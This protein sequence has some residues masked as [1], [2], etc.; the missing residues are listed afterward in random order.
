MYRSSDLSISH[1][2]RSSDGPARDPPLRADHFGCGARMVG[3]RCSKDYALEARADA[4]QRVL[5]CLKRC[6]AESW[7][8]LMLCSGQW[9]EVLVWWGV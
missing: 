3:P 1:V 6:Y 7:V 5:S 4:K 8:V 2:A 9:V